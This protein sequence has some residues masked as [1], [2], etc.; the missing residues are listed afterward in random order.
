MGAAISAERPLRRDAEANRQKILVAARAVFAERGL[1]ATLDD[2][3]HRAGVGV[4]T[5]YRKY[6][7]RDELVDALFEQAI[8]EL[9]DLASNAGQGRNP[10]DALAYFL[11]QACGQLASDRGLREIALDA[12]HGRGRLADA[13]QRLAEPIDRLVAAARA[14]G[15]LRADVEGTDLSAI[16]GMVVQIVEKLGDV[17]PDLWRRYLVL[18]LDG[19]RAQRRY[20]SDLGAP[21]LTDDEL[22]LVAA[23][24]HPQHR[25]PPC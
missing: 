7:C 23:G 22:E 14:D 8:D 17:R 9:A 24:A 2:V 18:L 21:P 20:A 15:R 1:E 5:V 12:C 10:W 19:L 13:R 6:V 16:I 3:A 4:G 25:Y 11:E